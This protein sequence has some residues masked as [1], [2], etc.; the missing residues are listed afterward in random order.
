MVQPTDER[1]RRNASDPKLQF[2]KP[3]LLQRLRIGP[4]RRCAWGRWANTLP[5]GHTLGFVTA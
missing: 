3:W 2:R 1:M 4:K 5:F